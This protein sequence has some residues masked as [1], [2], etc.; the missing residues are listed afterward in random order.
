MGVWLPVSALA[1][2]RLRRTGYALDPLPLSPEELRAGLD[3]LDAP[4]A[5]DAPAAPAAPASAAPTVR[6]TDTADRADPRR[7]AAD[8]HTGP[9]NGTTARSASTPLISVRGLTL[10]RGRTEVLH[11]IDLDIAAGAA[12]SGASAVSGATVVSAAAAAVVVVSSSA[13]STYRSAR[14]RSP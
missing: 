10:R 4:D 7:N 9:A 5:A 8:P 14:S 12:V 11:G 1:A 6:R 3:A 2:L 13:R